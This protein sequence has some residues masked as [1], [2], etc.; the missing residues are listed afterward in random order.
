MDGQLAGERWAQRFDVALADPMLADLR[1]HMALNDAMLTSYTAA[2]R[3]TGKPLTLPQQERVHKLMEMQGRLAEREARRLRDLGTMVTQ[4]Q[5]M[6]LANLCL[7][8]FVEYVPDLKT[9]GEIQR[10]IVGQLLVSGRQRPATVVDDEGATYEWAR[11]NV[12]VF[13]QARAAVGGLPVLI[14][15]QPT[16]TDAA[17]RA[18]SDIT[19]KWSKQL[20]MPATAKTSG[21]TTTWTGCCGTTWG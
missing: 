2:L 20:P 11:V 8:L 17:G 16:T 12:A 13:D 14:D 6:A 9:R 5:F 7:Q 18:G 15:G 19:W 1:Q 4:A 10:R 21:T 3:N